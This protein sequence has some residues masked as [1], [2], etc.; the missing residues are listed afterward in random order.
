MHYTIKQ[1]A[2]LS[3]VSTRTLRHYDALG[4]LK[5]SHYTEVGYRLYG[6]AEVNRLQK[7]LFYKELDVPLQEIEKLLEESQQDV[8]RLETHLLALQQKHYRLRVVIETLTRTIE[9][10]KGGRKMSHSEKFQGF[11]ESWIA[12]NEQTYGKEVREEYGDEVVDASNAKIIGLTEEKFL[13][14]KQTEQQFL[15]ALLQALDENDVVGEHAK[16]AVKLHKKWLCYSW[17]SY[18]TQAHQ[19]LAEMYVADLRFTEYY[20]KHRAGATQFLRDAIHIHTK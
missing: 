11:K 7:I 17:P 12:E 4:L 13:E 8:D 15:E 20:D 18:S 1:L 9:E 14:M 16:E 10:K 2:E 19:G 6:E 3:G 5:P